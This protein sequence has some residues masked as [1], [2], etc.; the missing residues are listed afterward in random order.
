MGITLLSMGGLLAPLHS[1][2]GWFA[3]APRRAA[4]PALRA[5]VRPAASRVCAP[6][7]SAAAVSHERPRRPLRIVRVM[8]S[9]NAA[10]A[11]RM[12]MSGRMADVCAEL[13]RLAALEAAAG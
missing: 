2:M 5:A 12:F 4:T 1:L 13:D 11:G 7:P 8:E 3:P 6:R 9:A 10:G